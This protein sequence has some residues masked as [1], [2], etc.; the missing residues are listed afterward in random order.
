MNKVVLLALVG[1]LALLTEGCSFFS[2]FIEARK[3]LENEPIKPVP[4][5]VNTAQNNSQTTQEQDE[6]IFADLEE[7]GVEVAQTVVGLIPAT[8]PDVRVRGSVR[9]RS[10]PFSVV[11]LNPQIE[12]EKPEQEEKPVN[13]T[14]NNRD[15]R[16]SRAQEQTNNRSN[17]ADLPEPPPVVPTLAR[18]VVISGLFEANG[19]TRIIVQAP[20]E[21]SS[22]YVEVGQ[23]LS[24]GQILVKSI[25]KNHF[26]APRVILEEAGIEV[27]KTI[28]GN[29]AEEQLSS[30]PTK[31]LNK[32]TWVSSISSNSN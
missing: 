19:R 15:N 31:V 11:T 18:D 30:L 23:Y 21:S 20:N 17:T 7:E 27:A 2:D 32:Q 26:P 14:R 29:N 6:E 4:V 12:I 25:D 16:S 9:G 5:K 8:N 10:D 3:E 1:S 13:N 22:R 24:N 28:G